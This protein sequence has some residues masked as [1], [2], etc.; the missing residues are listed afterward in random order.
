MNSDMSLIDVGCGNGGSLL[1]LHSRFRDCVGIDITEAGINA[2]RNALTQSGIENCRGEVGDA[3]NSLGTEKY[4]RLISFEVL[5]HV[6]DDVQAAGN[7]YCALTPGGMAAVTV[8][9]KWWIFE[10]HGAYLPLL[11][12]NRVP[13]FSWLP[14]P[15]HERFAKAR[16]YTRKRITGVLAEA[17]FEILHVM[18]VTAPMDVIKWP[19]LRKFL[20]KTLFKPHATPIP[21]LATAIMVIAGKKEN[22]DRG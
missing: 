16:I 2:F 13:F 18:Y 3:Q 14:K 1:R 6:Q 12:W 10:T 19:P 9:N 15:V 22:Q 4:D 7:M 11:P 20:R 5:E 21:F 8:P 17:G